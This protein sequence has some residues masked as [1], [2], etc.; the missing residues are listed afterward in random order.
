MASDH[1]PSTGFPK[2]DV[3][4]LFQEPIKPVN[5]STDFSELSENVVVKVD[6][7][8]SLLR[9]MALLTNNFDKIYVRNS[10][11]AMVA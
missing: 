6:W 4:K 9:L 5:D 11:I 1:S 8:Q 7:P 2:K 10:L 3:I